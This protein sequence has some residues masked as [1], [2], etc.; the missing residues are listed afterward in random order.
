MDSKN[1][2]KIFKRLGNQLKSAREKTKLT[3]AEAADLA[4]I[5]VNYYARIERG[6]ENPTFE[7]LHRI[8]NALKIESDLV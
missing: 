5:H 1:D 3:Q 7:V 2:E 8:K 6:E 4:G